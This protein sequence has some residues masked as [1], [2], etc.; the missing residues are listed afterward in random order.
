MALDEPA[1]AMVS[2]V[3]IWLSGALLI[4]ESVVALLAAVSAASSSAIWFSSR[5]VYNSVGDLS[6]NQ[7]VISIR[8]KFPIC[9]RTRSNPV[10]MT[11]K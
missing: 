10:F 9:T 6:R 3:E 5:C 2:C 7:G 8:V 4:G 1:Q 11:R